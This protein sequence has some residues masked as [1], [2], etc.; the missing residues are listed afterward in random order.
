MSSLT[1][2]LA[3]LSA[4]PPLST[5][6][7]QSGWRQTGRYE[8]VLRL[9][10]AFPRAYPGKVRCER[11]GTTPEGRPMVALVASQDGALEPRAVRARK[12]PVVLFQGGIHAGEIDGKDAGFWLLRDLLDGKVLPGVLGKLTA[13]FIPVFNVDGHERFGPH[14]RPNQ[15]GPEQMGWRTTAQNYNLNRDYA[16][17]ETPEMAAMLRLLERW[18]PLVYLDLHATDGAK[19]QHDVAVTME[20]LLLGAPELRPL[21]ERAHQAV[22]DE[23]TAGGHLPLPFYPWF[24]KQDDPSSGFALGV[25]PPRLSNGYWFLRNRFVV[26]VETHSWKDYPAR[27]KATRDVVQAYLRLAAENGTAWLAAAR[28]ADA[29]D[30]QPDS[31]DVV[32]ALEPPASPARSSSRVMPTRSSP[33]RCPGRAGF[34]MTTPGPRCGRCPSST[35]CS[36]L[37]SRR[38][39]R[40]GTLSPPPTPSGCGRSFR[41]TASP[42]RR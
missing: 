19:F 7:E 16:K 20:P 13:V 25:P 29:R 39:P 38:R 6:A 40:A 4:A 2:V 9:C 24:L 30:R 33:R 10:R 26:L 17:A 18:D 28:A 12:R 22:M 23:L 14:H 41:C 27:V 1:V 3:L 11:F 42:A 37:S 15:V 34:A 35:S 21:G 32:L 36:R 5:L 31:L 8:E